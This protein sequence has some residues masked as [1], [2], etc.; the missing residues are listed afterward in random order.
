MWGL[1]TCSVVYLGF[2]KTKKLK[3]SADKTKL[4]ANTYRFTELSEYKKIRSY[5]MRLLIIGTTI[6][7]CLVSVLSILTARPVLSG[8]VTPEQ[9]NR[10]IMLCL[11]VSGSMASV[12]KILFERFEQLVNDFDGQRIGLTVFNETAISVFPITDDYDIIK[13]QLA[14]AKKAFAA[15]SQGVDGSIV[16]PDDEEAYEAYS[17]ITTGTNATSQERGASLA[18][19]GLASC[20]GKMGGNETRRSQSIVFATDNEAAG[21]QLYTTTQA[22]E[23]ALENSIRVY[24]IDPGSS[25]IGSGSSSD[26]DHEELEKS[27]ILTKGK[28]FKLDDTT[29]I[30]SII[31]AISEQEATFFTGSSEVTRTDQPTIFIILSIVFLAAYLVIISRLKL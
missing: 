18:G 1:I 29:A 30:S 8:S 15:I 16:L 20:V 14:L 5:F 23:L 26:K 6:L 27:A 9:K 25:E 17:Y 13:E 10:D 28:Y 3:K 11:D 19:D 4:V 12:D 21:E 22:A 24:A 7:I 2:K 31:D